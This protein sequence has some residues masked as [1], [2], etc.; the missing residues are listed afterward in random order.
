MEDQRYMVI[1]TIISISLRSI[2]FTR[3]KRF[4]DPL[5]IVVILKTDLK[6]KKT[7]KVLLFRTDLNLSCEN[8]IWYYRLRFQIEFTFRDAKQHFG[9]EDFMVLSEQSVSNATHL[10]FFCLNLSQVLMQKTGEQSIINLKFRCHSHYYTTKK[11]KIVSKCGYSIKKDE[12]LEDVPI[13]GL[14]HRRKNIA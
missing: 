10:S 4:S 1:R 3:H 5:N 7:A 2:L 12:I 14:I 13:L 8:M 9:L 6:T 11:L